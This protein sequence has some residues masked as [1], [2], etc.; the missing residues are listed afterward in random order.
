MGPDML[1]DKAA[2]V[3]L[4]G[5]IQNRK[6]IKIKP[7]VD[8]PTAQENFKKA[9]TLAEAMRPKCEAHVSDANATV[10]KSWKL[11]YYH[12]TFCMMYADILLAHSLG[13]LDKA[14]ALFKKMIDVF[15]RIEL[16]IAGEFDLFLFK[17]SVQNKLGVTI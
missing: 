6:K 10:R 9:M 16:E 3:D 8:N 1:Q 11:L 12:T 4:D 17:Q 5:D 14:V 15:S 13:D 7:W 2:I